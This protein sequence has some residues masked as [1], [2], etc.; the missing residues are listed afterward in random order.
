MS[1]VVLLARHATH[2]EVGKRLSG[3]SEIALSEE[4]RAEAGWLAERLRRYPIEAIHSSP[5]RRAFE[6]A[7]IVAGRSS[8]EVQTVDALDEIDFGG[9]TGQSFTGL[10]ED[11]Q[12]QRWNSARSAATPPGG[13]SMAEA[14]GRAVAHVE[15]VARGKGLTLLV[16]HCDIIRGVVAHYLGLVLDRMLRF[17]VNPASLTILDVGSRGGR[18]VALNERCERE[19]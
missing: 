19:R 12:W 16:T 18:L 10:E 5:R 14:A 2:G 8:I 17:D 11:P 13:E 6:T 1:S 9:W 15:A 4:G 3:R 7:E